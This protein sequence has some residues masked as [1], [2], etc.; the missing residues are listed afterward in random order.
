MFEHT[1][2][3]QSGS[4]VLSLSVISPCTIQT[5]EYISESSIFKKMACDTHF[6]D[7]FHVFFETSARLSGLK[8]L[9]MVS[10]LF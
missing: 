4:A 5:S 1:L 2:L 3:S 8:T 10:G 7:D 6:S 9:V